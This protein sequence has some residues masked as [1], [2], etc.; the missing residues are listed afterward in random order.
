MFDTMTLTKATGA[1]CGS[2]LVFLLGGWVAESIYATG[3]GHG[4]EHV[5]GFVIE[6]GADETEVVAEAGPSFAELFAAADMANGEKVFR[7][8][9][10]CH[11]LE[12][13]E[14]KAGPYLYGV[15]GRD[16]GTAEG[17]AAYSGALTAVV[18]VWTPEAL[19]AFLENPRG[20]A[21]GTS[22]GYAGLR[23]AQD[24]ADLIAFLDQTDGTT[25]EM[26]AA[27]T[28]PAE[29]APAA[30]EASDEA[31]AEEEAAVEAPAEEA[32][33]EAAPEAAAEAA[34]AATE[35]PVAEA[36]PEPSEEAAAEPAAEAAPEPAAE[37]PAA[38]GFAALVAA[39]DVA[40]GEKLFRRC[41]ACHAVEPGKNK[42]GP[43]LFGVVGRDIASVE[44]FSYS[45]ALSGLE[46]DW[47]LDKLSAWIENPRAYAPGNRMGF[48]GLKDEGDRA[49]LI[50]YLA[51]LGN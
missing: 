42:A 17:Y 28:A 36:A 20:Y 6:T 5:Q 40:E 47:T 23:K 7:N 26:P 34:P 1:L 38:E 44:G 30:P 31:A 8:C 25:Y 11:A 35:E 37:A 32:V 15:V 27:A 48:P 21:P 10:A 18:D 29:E 13:G 12:K 16:V 3:G 24:R 9:A 33:A 46:G 41:A 49:N 43:S 39:A 2:L 19:D 14:N 51:T 50:G 4:D 22:M 45:D